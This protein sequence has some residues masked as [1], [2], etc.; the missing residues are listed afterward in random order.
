MILTGL[1]R[2]DIPESKKMEL[3][4]YVYICMKDLEGEYL[5]A[6]IEFIIDLISAGNTTNCTIWKDILPRAIDLMIYNFNEEDV[7]GHDENG[8]T[9]SEFVENMIAKLLK[10]EWSLRDLIGIAYMLKELETT[11]TERFALV[12]KLSRLSARLKP[13]D[14]TTLSHHMFRISDEPKLILSVIFSLDSY[15]QKNLY[16]TD[17]NSQT[18]SSIA[19]ELSTCG[20]NFLKMCQDAE[21]TILFNLHNNT[22]FRVEE[23]KVALTCRFFTV[24]PNRIL[25]PF[26]LSALLVLSN[27]NRY[28]DITKLGQSKILPLVISCIKTNESEAKL[29]ET[30]F[31]LNQKL[32][33]YCAVDVARLF[34]HLIKNTQKGFDIVT[35]GLVGLLFLLLK[36]EQDE[37]ISLLID[38]F[39]AKFLLQRPMFRKGIIKSLAQV[40]L[41]RLWEEIEKV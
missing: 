24:W 39:L 6:L 41:R 11:P 10:G 2:A 22:E 9:G 23:H 4:T 27:L 20:N 37:S 3:T 19:S 31:Y 30:S 13:I 36:Q 17:Q 32:A 34:F 21:E 8:V 15:L 29:K 38:G 18:Q 25:T 16:G 7:S 12:Q 40:K 33:D 1:G 14:L 26:A 28:T 35:S 5:A